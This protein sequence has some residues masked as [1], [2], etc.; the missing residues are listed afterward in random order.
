VGSSMKLKQ[1][2]KLLRARRSAKH[3]L[4]VHARR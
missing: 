1:L 3:L 2:V 4:G